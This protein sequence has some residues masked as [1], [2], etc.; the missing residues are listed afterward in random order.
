MF[1]Q[2]GGT[3]DLSLQV[4]IPNEF[5][6]LA[7][8]N[9]GY[10]AG[11]ETSKLAHQWILKCNEMD[12]I[13][14]ISSFSKSIF[15]STE[16]EA[17]NR[18]T[19]EKVL[20]RTQ[21]P[22][23]FVNYPT[24]SYEQLPDIDLSVS[25][26]FNFLT[27]AQ[28]GPRKNLQNTIK[29][30]IEEFRDE[31]VGLIVKSNIAKNCLMDRNRLYEQLRGLINQQGEKNCKV[32]LLH[33]DMTDE[34]MHSLYKHDRV[35]AF[36]ALPHGE[37]FGLPIFE[38]AYSGLPVV[39]T[40]WSGQLDYLIDSDGQE[41]FYNVA[42]DLQ[43]VQ[44]EVV[45]DGVLVADSMW[46]Y[47]REGSAKEKMRLCYENAKIGTIVWNNTRLPECFSAKKQYTKFV[48]IITDTYNEDCHTIDNEEWW[49]DNN[50]VVEYG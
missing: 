46:A 28:S 24:K 8:V 11:I 18:D 1:M 34:E 43:P 16:Y 15:D 35:D 23:E 27:V 49:K 36:L 5:Q 31:D 42:F 2:Q 38:A 17:H 47:A 25:T 4:T 26:S 7:K 6:N 39:A 40:G 3:F 48:D 9:I 32:Y 37:G 45:W 30:F 14:T 50:E 20:L 29:W 22:V 13:I 44:K 33:G 10:T 12:K 19:G 41:Q 21:V